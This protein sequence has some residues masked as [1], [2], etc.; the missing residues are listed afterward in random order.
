MDP[1]DRP[2]E[3][4][5]KRTSIGRA[6]LWLGTVLA[7]S[8]GLYWLT[9]AVDDGAP[10]ASIGTSILLILPFSVGAI[11]EL[12]LNSSNSRSNTLYN[13]ATAIAVTLVAGAIIFREGL[14][15]LVMLAPL[16]I[17]AAVIGA[18]AVVLTRE[19]FG[20]RDRSNAAVVLALPFLALFA[21]ANFP[22]PVERF[23]VS[24]STVIDARPAEIWP[25]LLQLEGLRPEEGVWNVTQDLLGIPRPSSAVVVGEGVGSVRLA[26]WGADIR[27][28][29]HITDWRLNERLAWDFAF[30]DDSVS[31]Y[32][33]P[34]I[35][36]DGANLKIAHGAYRLSPLSGGRT[37]LTLETSYLA[38]TPVNPYASLWGELA[39]G[40]IQTNILAVVK[41]RAEH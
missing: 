13:V 9:L 16:W 31:R 1:D 35:H 21:D 32:T 30:P 10:W 2:P 38:R 23:A 33:D 19:A 7:L 27:F 25:H 11:T 12:L 37:Q 15:C 6:A 18:Y 26:R 41:G 34:H 29:E 39:L 8:L 14:V 20:G 28:E 17:A 4:P 40:D 5:P 24:R 22:P 36:P 3:A